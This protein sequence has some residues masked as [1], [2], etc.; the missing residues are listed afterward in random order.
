MEPPSEARVLVARGMR[1]AVVAFVQVGG[2]PD[3][4]SHRYQLP[5]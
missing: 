1:K 4:A 2:L 5:A 3:Q